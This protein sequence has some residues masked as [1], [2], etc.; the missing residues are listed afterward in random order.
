MDLAEDDAADVIQGGEETSRKMS[1]TERMNAVRNNQCQQNL[2][3]ITNEIDKDKLENTKKL[4]LTTNR[5]R[6]DYKVLKLDQKKTEIEYRKRKDPTLDT[7]YDEKIM[8]HS[9]NYLRYDPGSASYL[10]SKLAIPVRVRKAPDTISP[11]VANARK[12]LHEKC[13]NATQKAT[14][15]VKNNDQARSGALDNVS[16]TQRLADDIQETSRSTCSVGEVNNLEW[17]GAPQSMQMEDNKQHTTQRPA[18]DAKQ[19][20]TIRQKRSIKLMK[21]Y[22]EPSQSQTKLGLP[23]SKS[24]LHNY[25]SLPETNWT[26][27]NAN[28]DINQTSLPSL[29]LRKLARKASEMSVNSDNNARKASEI[30]LHCEHNALL[31]PYVGL[32]EDSNVS[33]RSDRSTVRDQG[34]LLHGLQYKKKPEMAEIKKMMRAWSEENQ[35]NGK[36]KSSPRRNVG[37]SNSVVVKP[38]GDRPP[39]TAASLQEE[40]FQLASKVGKF[41]VNMQDMLPASL[42]NQQPPLNKNFPGD[43]GNIWQR[44]RNLISAANTFSRPI[45]RDAKRGFLHNKARIH[46]YNPPVDPSLTHPQPG[47][48]INTARR[49]V[50]QSVTFKLHR[51]ITNIVSKQTRAQALEYERAKRNLTPPE[52]FMQKPNFNFRSQVLQMI[53]EEE[54]IPSSG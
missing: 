45:S 11:L 27:S 5:I 37:R 25:K 21:S 20:S 10:D 17:T 1:L 30:G 53:P 3:G 39:I 9:A 29:R 8:L 48:P 50:R 14:T 4:E 36:T 28:M 51:I 15:K 49:A 40:K 34:Y 26:T 46:Q 35:A 18:A 13:L 19:V 54:L 23:R 16:H 44:S 7:T 33:K 2:Q 41:L 38:V 47:I 22:G 6:Y 12:A 32:R 42:S 24:D 52:D 31:L 43:N